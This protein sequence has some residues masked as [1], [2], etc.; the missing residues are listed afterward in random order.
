MKKSRSYLLL[1]FRKTKII[2]TLIIP[3][4]KISSINKQGKMLLLMHYR[5]QIIARSV[6][7]IV[8]QTALIL[9]KPLS[10][11]AMYARMRDKIPSNFN[12]KTTNKSCTSYIIRLNNS[13]VFHNLHCLISN[14]IK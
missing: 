6:Y 7:R 4:H 11:V 8:V 1:V 13:I 2:I 14:K 5:R 10:R 3:Q 12:V 9:Q